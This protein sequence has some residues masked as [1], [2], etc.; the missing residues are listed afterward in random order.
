[1]SKRRSRSSAP[2]LPQETL[3][4]ARRQAAIDRGEL[5]P[6]EPPAEEE[7]APP[8]AKPASAAVESAAPRSRAAA[9][10]RPA[11]GARRVSGATT[12][13]H[14]SKSNELTPEMVAEMLAHPTIQVSEEDLHKQYAYVINDVRSMFALA[15]GLIV[16]LIVLSFILPRFGA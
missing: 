9:P 2:N 14:R 6:D 12:H 11:S 13:A 8:V 1:M 4:R 5:P 7:P 16:L 15:G 3:E 10:R